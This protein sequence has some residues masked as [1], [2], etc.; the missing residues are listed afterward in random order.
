MKVNGITTTFLMAALF[1]ITA[2]AA[3]Y[4]QA[5]I[6]NGKIK[7]VIYLPDSKTGFYRGLRFDWAGVVKSL[8]FAGHSFYG[9]WFTGTDPTVRDFVFKDKDIIAS[10]ASADSGPVEEFRGTLG[11]DTA[12]AG[13]TFIKIGVGVL[14]KPD[15]TAYSNYRIYEV[16][17]G[18]KWTIDTTPTSVTFTQT[19]DAP[20]IGYGY[21]YTK[22][23]RLAD[24]SP[25]L[26]IEHTLKNTGRLAIN[27]SVYDH[28]FLV[29]DGTPIGPGISVRVPY[30]IDSTRPPA[31]G[32]A[33]ISGTEFH[34][35][36]KVEN[37][38][39][40]SGTLA[41]FGKTSSDYDFRIENTMAGAGVRITGDRPLASASLWSI[42]SVMAVEPTVAVTAEPGA[43]F[44]WKY[45]YDYFT[46]AK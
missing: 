43:D 45:T 19:I 4:P 22:R 18:G 42:R 5:Q 3:D 36:K 34:Y 17:D 37:E 29:L 14:R 39:R 24:N 41:G 1:A 46:I 21:V 8:E 12:K 31:A 33:E 30:K 2:Q 32:T 26:N 27:A 16:V 35:L 25:Q 11:F 10:S 7:A 23:M 9:P 13:D 40:V 15:D 28:N 6:S 38:E 20:A 44:S